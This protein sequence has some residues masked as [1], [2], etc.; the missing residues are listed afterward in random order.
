MYK[1]KG[2]EVRQFTGRRSSQLKDQTLGTFGKL[3]GTYQKPGS[4]SAG[5]RHRAPFSFQVTGVRHKLK[6]CFSCK[7]ETIQIWRCKLIYPWE[8]KRALDKHTPSDPVLWPHDWGSCWVL[9]V[10]WTF[11]TITNHQPSHMSADNIM[12]FRSWRKE[13]L[14]YYR[15][16]RIA[17]LWIFPQKQMRPAVDVIFQKL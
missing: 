12:A 9:L 7:T 5:E 8:N 13:G 15:T 14:W 3:C 1:N 16:S 10:P 6:V 2:S 11:S 17:S 4:V